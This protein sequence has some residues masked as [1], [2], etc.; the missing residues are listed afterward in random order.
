MEKAVFDSSTQRHHWRHLFGQNDIFEDRSVDRIPSPSHPVLPPS[1]TFTLPSPLLN[2]IRMDDTKVNDTMTANVCLQSN[3]DFVGGIVAGVHGAESK[4]APLKSV[5]RALVKV[6]EKY[7]CNFAML[8]DLARITIVCD[9]EFTLKSVLLKL[10][11]AV[12]EKI[13]TINRIK[14]RLDEKYDAME[15]GG[16]RDILINLF[17]PPQEE[18]ESEH[19]VELQ[20]NLKKFVQ[21]KDGG[22]HASY[23]VG[24]ML[25]AFDAA[26]V[27]YTG[28]INQESA[29]DIGIGLI[30]KATLV[31]VDDVELRGIGKRSIKRAL[32]TE[33]KL[34]QALGSSVV[35]LVELKLLNIKFSSVDMASL[36]W[37]AASA[38]H[39]AA[40]L[41][42]LQIN[43][44]KVKGPI[45]PAVGMLH[46]LVTLD[47]LMNNID[48]ARQAKFL[49]WIF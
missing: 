22:G 2:S 37:L 19:M 49:L 23:A 7:E 31:G 47:L 13:T 18:K 39:L 38:I 30:K 42:V 29:R 33:I 46:Q 36:S 17:F 16:Y 21:I 11:A 10:K 32:E 41:K 35:Q 20:L 25:Q 4:R 1:L 14:F 43:S 15:A 34:T 27:T 24:R 28:M 44:C 3:D 9:D 8:T 45:P 40:T 26:A 5:E 12:Y 6:Y 48:G